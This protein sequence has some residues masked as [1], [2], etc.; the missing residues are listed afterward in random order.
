MPNFSALLRLGVFLALAL[1]ATARAWENRFP[2]GRYK[3]VV[4]GGQ[5]YHVLKVDLCAAGI[6]VRAT[7]PGEK[8]QVVSHFGASVGASA[9]VNGDFFTAGFATDGP[10]RGDGRA[11][12]GDDHGY[13]APVSFGRYA[14]GMA[15]HGERGGPPDW[16]E[17]VVS[18]HPTLL[19]DGAVVGNPN[20]PLCTL[21]NPRTAVGLSED[22]QKL[23]LVVVDGRRAGAAGMTCPEVAEVLTG[24][25]AFDATA[26]DGGGSSTLWLKDG[27]V[28][29]Q[30]SDGHERTVANHLAIIADGVGWAHN[31]PVPEYRAAFV[32]QSYPLSQDGAQIVHLG[33]TVTG[34]I[35]LRNTG[36]LPWDAATKLAPIPRDAPSPLAAASWLAPNR[37]SSVAAPTT[38]DAVGHF[39]LD[40]TGTALG[41]YT[42]KFGVLQEGVTWFADNGGP[43]DDLLTVRVSVVPP[44]DAGRDAAVDAGR[45]ASVVRTPDARPDDPGLHHPP[46]DAAWALDGAV[47]G[48]D[49][50]PVEDRDATESARG[51]AAS[52]G[53]GV[54]G[55]RAVSGAW[56]WGVV[57][58]VGR[59]RLRSTVS[60]AAGPTS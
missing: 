43:S 45:D 30:P 57:A 56:L 38:T 52:G 8:G 40:L 48:A 42:L 53:C 13:V 20:D 14:A 47:L 36:R 16:A 10:A 9:A 33:E 44:L 28:M 50:R 24:E 29:N 34:S 4:R 7:K 18:G 26:L 35:D 12:G 60:R 23:I 58:A 46:A 51:V 54:A 6:H 59:R 37:V 11:W 21:R 49:T 31:C 41:E 1:P 55:G 19:N 27:G 32:G 2:G 22:H 5:D 3:H 39:A 25:G 17:Q 15:P